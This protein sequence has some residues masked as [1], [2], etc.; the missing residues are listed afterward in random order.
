MTTALPDPLDLQ[1]IKDRVRKRAAVQGPR[2]GDWVIMSDGSTE[3]LT[4]R[5]GERSTYLFPGQPWPI[6]AIPDRKHPHRVSHPCFVTDFE[7]RGS[8]M[9]HDDGTVGHSGGNDFHN[10]S[11]RAKM[12]DTGQTKAGKFRAFK[13]FHPDLDNEERG[14]VTG[15]RGVEFELPCRVYR[16]SEDG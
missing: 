4:G 14:R 12:I 2:V 15:R 5:L 3:R 16:L 8:F 10:V 1:V 7:R 9:L 13:S 11:R 6:D